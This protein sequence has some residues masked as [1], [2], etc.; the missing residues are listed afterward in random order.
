LPRAWRGDSLRDFNYLGNGGEGGLE[1]ATSAARVRGL[2]IFSKKWKSTDGAASD[3]NDIVGNA[4]AHR[5]VYLA[6]NDLTVPFLGGFQSTAPV[7]RTI[8]VLSVRKSLAHSWRTISEPRLRAPD[9]LK[10]DPSSF[11]DARSAF[12]LA[13]HKASELG[14]RHAHGITPMLHKPIAQIWRCQ[15]TCDVLR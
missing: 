10:F 5:S 1:L 15:C 14:L 12:T 7:R 3:W 13:H 11:G 8:S 6:S 4:R 2:K 9:S